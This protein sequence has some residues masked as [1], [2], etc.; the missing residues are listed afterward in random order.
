LRQHNKFIT[1]KDRS[2]DIYLLAESPG[3]GKGANWLPAKRVP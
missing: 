1:N 2:V 3:K